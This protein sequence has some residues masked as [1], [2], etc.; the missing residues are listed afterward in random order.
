MHGIDYNETYAPVVALATVCTVLAVAAHL[1]LELEQMEVVTAFLNGNLEEDIYMSIPEGLVSNSIR[2]KVCMLRKSLYGLKQ[3]PRQWYAKIHDFLIR[4]RKF[5]SSSNDP[6]LYIRH[7]DSKV[8]LVALYADDLLIASKSKSDIC[9]L[10]R[11]L[12]GKFEMKDLGP[13]KMM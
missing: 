4:E 2:N 12:S 11:G 5:K 9:A 10:K 13:T 7:E 6:C 3:S 8:L 1:D